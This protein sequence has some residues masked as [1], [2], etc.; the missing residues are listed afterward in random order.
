MMQGP[1]LALALLMTAGYASAQPVTPSTVTPVFW[2]G[3]AVSTSPCAAYPLYLDFAPSAPL[4]CYN[5]AT[6]SAPPSFTGLTE[7]PGVVSGAGAGG[8]MV[9]NAAGGLTNITSGSGLSTTAGFFVESA[10]ENDVFKSTDPS[11]SP[12]SLFNVT[13]TTNTTVAPD[14]TTTGATLTDTATNQGDFDGRYV[15]IRT[16]MLVTSGRI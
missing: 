1:L 6:T 9:P 12:W 16:K 5:N 2:H 14:G 4:Q 7:T 8:T 10:S 11:A 15:T 13:V 3:I